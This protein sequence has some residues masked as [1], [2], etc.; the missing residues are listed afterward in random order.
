[1]LPSERLADAKIEH[2]EVAQSVA[3]QKAKLTEVLKS[4]NFHLQVLLAIL[5]LSHL[6]RLFIALIIEPFSSL[7]IVHS[8][9]Y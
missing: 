7:Q 4:I 2:R 9:D 5:N 8:P 3:S 1:M 6:D